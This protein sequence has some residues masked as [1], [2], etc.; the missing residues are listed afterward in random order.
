MAGR[1]DDVGRASV[2]LVTGFGP[3]GEVANLEVDRRG[4]LGRVLAGLRKMHGGGRG[5]KLEGRAF[6]ELPDGTGVLA[7]LHWYEAHGVGRKD[8]KVKRLLE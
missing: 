2:R 4:Q 7:E 1:G 8:V 3:R 6:V 5:R